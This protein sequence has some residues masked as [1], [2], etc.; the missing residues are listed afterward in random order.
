MF[1]VY[2]DISNFSQHWPLKL[3]LIILVEIHI[4]Q[5]IM[6]AVAV[7]CVANRTYFGF[8]VKLAELTPFIY[9]Y[10]YNRDARP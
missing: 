6:Q 10:R 9:K 7:N 5:N 1:E 2:P 4:F 8:E 3:N